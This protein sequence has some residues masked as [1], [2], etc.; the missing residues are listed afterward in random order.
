MKRRIITIAWVLMLLS[1]A[2]NVKAQDNWEPQ[3]RITGYIST[4][5]NAFDD[6]K[7][8]DNNYGVTLAEAGLLTTY[9]PTENLTF[10]AVFV[11]RPDF[12]FNQMLNEANIQYKLGEKT[13][14]KAG[15]FLTPLSPMNTY[16]YAPVN[17]SAT[18][19]VLVSNH[20]FFPLNMDAVSLNG[21]IGSN[22]TFSYEVFAGGYRNTT[23]MKTGAVGFF[24][25]E[26]AYYK[27]IIQSD[28]T[29]HQGYN[30]SYNVALGGNIR[31]AYQDYIKVGFNVF[32][33]KNEY[34]PVYL[35]K[36]DMVKE[37]ET[38]KLTYGLD[39]KLA[40]NNTKVIGEFWNSDFSI[41]PDEVDLKGSFIELSQMINKFT[42][43]ARY[44]YQT[45]NDIE[46][47]R[48]TAGL[49]FKPT[50]ESSFKLE[51]LHYEHKVQDIDGM[52]LSFIYSF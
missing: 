22:L 12:S 50:F 36:F 1:A 37:L 43:Y 11:Y 25:D 48:Y 19:P 44:E 7:G 27:N 28:Y 17:S 9:Q 35:T 5:F 32:K 2:F 6:L 42:P 33:P 52:V 41:G 4:E 26:V 23:W 45:T 31:L 20:E 10:K 30:N 15:R 29:I 16:Y 3:K 40:L 51:Y 46:F 38:D 8:Y 18:L 49:M 21:H 14:I 34:I 13:N 24:G 47:E 39:F